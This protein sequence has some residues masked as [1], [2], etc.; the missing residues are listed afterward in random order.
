[1]K[2]HKI[3][4]INKIRFFKCNNC[5]DNCVYIKSFN[6]KPVCDNG[7]E[8][9]FTE[10]SRLRAWIIDIKNSVKHILFAKE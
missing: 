2:I 4:I 9:N 7:R 1:M 3:K 8:A 5:G 10:V 6:I